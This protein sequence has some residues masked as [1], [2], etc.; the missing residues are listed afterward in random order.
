MGDSLSNYAKL[1]IEEADKTQ[2]KRSKAIELLTAY[3]QNEKIVG[4]WQ[5]VMFGSCEVGFALKQ[6][7]V[8][9][10]LKV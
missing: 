7:D 6:S 4:A 9:L 2:S 3:L 8:D 1:L 5:L 10:V